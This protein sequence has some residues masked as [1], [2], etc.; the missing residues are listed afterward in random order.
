MFPDVRYKEEQEF[1]VKEFPV[2]SDHLIVLRRT[3]AHRHP[4]DSVRGLVGVFPS[5]KLVK[6]P[7]SLRF[8]SFN[9][10]RT[11]YGALRDMEQMLADFYLRSD[12]LP[13]VIPFPERAFEKKR[14]PET[15]MAALYHRGALIYDSEE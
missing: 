14:L 8:Y 6:Q 3:L 7:S 11:I 4:P 2:L 15:V 13:L 5:R 1:P 12:I 9:R 10:N